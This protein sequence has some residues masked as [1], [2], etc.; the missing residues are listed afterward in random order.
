LRRPKTREN[1]RPPRPDAKRADR[2]TVTDRS[3]FAHILDAGVSIGN[4]AKF[5]GDTPEAIMRTYCH[6]TD[7]DVSATIGAMFGPPPAEDKKET[8]TKGNRQK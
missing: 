1:R 8:H 3:P 2:T 7:L 4:V 5:L 6:G